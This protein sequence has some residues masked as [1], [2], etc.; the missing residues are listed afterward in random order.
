MANAIDFYVT[1]DP[2]TGKCCISDTIKKEYSFR[3]I[4]AV[5]LATANEFEQWKAQFEDLPPPL[6]AEDRREW[7]SKLNDVSLSSDAFF[8]FRD[9]VDRAKQVTKKYLL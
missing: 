4:C 9:N 2:A 8:P 6:T 5:K 7:I 3:L 1:S